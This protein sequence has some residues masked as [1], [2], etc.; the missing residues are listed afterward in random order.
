MVNWYIVLN[1]GDTFSPSNGCK[2]VII[3]NAALDNASLE[4]LENGHMKYVIDGS[5]PNAVSVH[6][7]HSILEDRLM[8]L[9]ALDNSESGDIL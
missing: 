9:I 5:L 8:G 2:L 6:D 4:S 1:D 7:V 3:D